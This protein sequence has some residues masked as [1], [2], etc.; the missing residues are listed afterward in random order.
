MTQPC[1]PCFQTKKSKSIIYFIKYSIILKYLVDV[2][3]I[4]VHMVYSGTSYS[5]DYNY[6][7]NN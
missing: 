3:W 1:R 7:M 5:N 2:G 6:V 4:L